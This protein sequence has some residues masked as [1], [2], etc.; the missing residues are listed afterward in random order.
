MKLTLALPALLR[1]PDE[2]PPP[3][4]LPAFNQILRYGRLQRHAQ[5]PSEFYARYLWRGSLLAQAKRALNLPEHQIAV[6]ASP[7]WQQMGMNHVSMIGGEHIGILPDEAERLCADL[8][9][10]YAQD[11]WR[12][13]P[14][15]PDLW[16]AT[17][18]SEPD[19]QVAPVLDVCG[20]IG[21]PEA[22]EGANALIWLGKQTEIQMWLHGHPLNGKRIAC[23]QPAVNGLW[24]WTDLVGSQTAILTASD[25]PWAQS[26]DGLKADAPYDFQAWQEIVAEQGQKVSDGLIFLDDLI[27][28]AQTGDVWAYQEI[29]ESWETRWFAPLWQEVCAGRLKELVIATDGENGGEVVVT[30]QSKWA[31]WRKGKPFDGIAL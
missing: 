28:T 27:A 6:F 20:Q 7:L 4:K 22:A 18:P 13:Y 30:P 3:L 17:L 23:K 29:L 9:A 12:F 24:L 31:F 26:S 15:R 11:S 1:R 14:W 5:R 21:N 2:T 10:F 19:W 16:L 25:S 8:S